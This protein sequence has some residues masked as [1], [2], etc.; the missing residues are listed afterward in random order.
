MGRRTLGGSN[1]TLRSI[2]AVVAGMLVGIV[3]SIATDALIHAIGYFPPIGQPLSSGP[4]IPATIYRAIYG[5]IGAY[6]TA[7]LAPNRPMLHAMVLGILGLIVC[8]AG[9]IFTWNRGP[10]F[11]PHWY[12]L[13]LVVLALPTAW[14]GGKLGE[15]NVANR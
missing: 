12:P 7:R 1:T 8:I 10:A 4:L 13:A 6:V 5:V 14:L 9:A 11:G 15:R 2:G 3:L